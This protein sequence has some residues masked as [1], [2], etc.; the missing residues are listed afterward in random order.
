MGVETKPWS[1]YELLQNGWLELNFPWRNHQAIRGLRWDQVPWDVL[2][3]HRLH[4]KDLNLSIPHQ[5]ARTIHRQSV[6]AV[7]KIIKR[8]VQIV[9]VP[10]EN[11][12]NAQTSQIP[13]SQI[14]LWAHFTHDLELPVVDGRWD[15]FILEVKAPLRRPQEVHKKEHE[16]WGWKVLSRESGQDPDAVFQD[17]P[18]DVQLLRTVEQ[19]WSIILEKRYPDVP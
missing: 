6:K 2:I 8:I 14:R 5:A 3:N 19:Q 12:K 13:R 11:Y 10:V 15:L 18:Q 1:R 4:K 7:P 16:R 9:I 17:A